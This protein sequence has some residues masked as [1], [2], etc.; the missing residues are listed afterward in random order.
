MSDGDSGDSSPNEDAESND[1]DDDGIEGKDC[2]DDDVESKDSLH[3]TE[4]KDSLDDGF[5]RKG[6]SAENNDP[7]DEKS[8]DGFSAAALCVRAG[9]W[10]EPDNL[11]GLAHFLEHM[12]FMGSQKYPNENDF[13]C[14]IKE[15]GG[16]TNANTHAEW[17]SYFFDVQDVAFKPA[18]DRFANFFIH[19]LMSMKSVERE[20]KMIHSEWMMKARNEKIRFEQLLG[21]MAREGHPIGKF[22]WGNQESL[23]SLPALSRIDVCQALRTFWRQHYLAQYMT[24]VVL[25]K[26][27]LDVLQSWVVEIFE[28]ISG[29]CHLTHHSSDVFTELYPVGA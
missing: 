2:I 16:Q 28:G 3:D 20:V 8:S 27:C 24:L 1:M 29:R 23:Q 19:P 10:M 12:L 21:T 25:S 14:F 26:E 17:T 13:D 6:G 11:P 15:H 9:S 18:L 22:T 4:S 7:L 5:Q